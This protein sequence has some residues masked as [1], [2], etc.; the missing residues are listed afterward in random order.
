MEGKE[1]GSHVSKEEAR[2]KLYEFVHNPDHLELSAKE[3]DKIIEI[4]FNDVQ[5]LDWE[6]ALDVISDD[7]AKELGA[8]PDMREN[9][10][11]QRGRAKEEAQQFLD[12]MGYKR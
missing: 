4:V 12:D 9:A 3:C 10:R 8:D 1:H 11:Q 2:N 5:D 6:S 7:E